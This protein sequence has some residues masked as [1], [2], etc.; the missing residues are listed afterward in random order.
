MNS[1]DLPLPTNSD[2]SLSFFWIDAHEEN[3]GAE[4]YIFGKVW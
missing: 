4:L 1:Y 2:G 3:F